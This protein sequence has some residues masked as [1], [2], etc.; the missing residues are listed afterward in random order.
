MI[1]ALYLQIQNAPTAL[2]HSLELYFPSKED[3]RTV[4][5]RYSTIKIHSD[6]P[7]G[8]F[9][10]GYICFKV[11]DDALIVSN[12]LQKEINKYLGEIGDQSLLLV[13]LKYHDEN[14]NISPE[15]VYNWV[16]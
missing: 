3:I 14:D 10:S 11:I 4:S 12:N 6:L 2:S 15:I 9:L 1:K 8:P 7:N 16:K 13:Q 5:S